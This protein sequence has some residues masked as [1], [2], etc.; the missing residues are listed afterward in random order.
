[1]FVDPVPDAVRWAAAVGGDRVELYTE[2]FARAFESGRGDASFKTYA[3]AAELAHSLGLGVNA[4]HDLDLKNLQLFRRLPASRGS[5]DRP[6]AH[7][8]CAVCRP[9]AIRKGLS[10][11]ASLTMV[12]RPRTVVRVCSVHDR[13]LLC[14]MPRAFGAVS[15]LW[16]PRRAARHVSRR[17]WRDVECGVLRAIP[18]P[19]TGHRASSH[20]AAVAH[21]LGCGSR[22]AAFRCGLCR[23]RAGFS[24]RRRCRR[25][26]DRCESREGVSSRAAGSHSDRPSASPALRSAPISRS[27]DAADDPGVM[28]I[29]LLSPGLDYKGLRTEAAMKKYGGRSALLMGSTKDPY[30]ARSIRQLIAIGPGTR[31]VRLID[32]VGARNR[33]ACRA[34][35]AWSP[36]WWTGSN[37]HYNDRDR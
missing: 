25:L 32:A 4:G 20:A 15:N 28:S 8:P 10:G 6:C 11:C 19:G 29:A 21:G 33:A 13:A 16:R 27:L 35:P 30:S 23:A 24:R 3:E 1:M 22:V 26:A 14:A 36:R 34:I 9:R 31:E 7:Q 5:L 18:A 37:E 2:P 12:M 17:R